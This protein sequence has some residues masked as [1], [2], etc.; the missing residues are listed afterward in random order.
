MIRVT[1]LV[2]RY[3]GV[4]AVRNISFTVDKGEIV[5]FLGPNGAGK[6]TTMRILTGY[7]PATSGMV[8]I[9]GYNVL[10]ESLEVRKKIGYMPENIPL[11]YEMRVREYLEYRAAL[12]L[13]ERNQIR[14]S[15]SLAMDQCGVAD[16]G[17][18]I[19]GSLSKGYRQRVGLADALVHEPEL[20]ILDEP[21]AGLDP[22]QIRTA[23]ELI[24]ELGKERTILLST[25][26]LSEVEMV[27]SRALIINKGVIEASDT[28]E[29]LQK[30]VQSGS[31]FLEVKAAVASAVEK[32]EKIPHLSGVEVR[33][34]R[35]GWV[36]LECMAAPGEDIRQA[37]DE[38][39]R[40]ENWPLRE[41]RS[42]RATLEDV[43]VELTQE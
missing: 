40:K 9:A 39:I 19:I 4:D 30:K 43:F 20:L 7:L 31:L 27:C 14:E 8:K 22:N 26:I 34:D 1:N 13:V 12:K 10:T 33:S 28:I 23:R 15:V 11:Y 2:K 17:K 16:V 5:G 41:F 6:S 37:V 25:H 24:K 42:G 21:T 29:N 35:A 36:S 32:L 38:L 3:A 18:K